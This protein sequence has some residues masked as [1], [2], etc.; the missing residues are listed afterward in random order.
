M[1]IPLGPIGRLA[2]PDA[3]ESIERNPYLLL[4]APRQ[5]PHLLG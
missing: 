2:L 3:N 5:G 1:A 4:V